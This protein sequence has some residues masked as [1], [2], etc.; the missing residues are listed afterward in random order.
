MNAR[1]AACSVIIVLTLMTA[2]AG[3]YSPAL[4]TATFEITEWT[5]DYYEYLGEYSSYVHVYYKVTNTGTVHI[6]YYQ[7][8]IEVTCVDGSKY[9]E[10]TNGLNVACGTY[11]TDYTMINIAE[12]QAVSVSITNYELTSY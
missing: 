1:K 12:K 11:L 2:L 4:P 10:W 3:C 9:Q 8:W 5:Q 7:V 6:D